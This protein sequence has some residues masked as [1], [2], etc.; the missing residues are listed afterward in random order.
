MAKGVDVENYPGMPLENGGKMVQIMK[1]QARSFFTEVWDDT[2][3][4]ITLTSR[5]FV[6]RTNISGEVQSHTVIG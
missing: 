3:L 6:L 4:D 1:T 5:P 2:V